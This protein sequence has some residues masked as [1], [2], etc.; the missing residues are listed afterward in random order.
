LDGFN[1]YH[2]ADARIQ[3]TTANILNRFVNTTAN[4]MI[5]A[6]PSGQTVAQGG[7][8]G[9][10][11]TINP[12]GGFTGQVTLSVTGLPNGASGGFTANPAT[13]S[14][15]LSVTTSPSTP[16]GTYALIITGVSGALIHSTTVSL[17]VAPPGVAFDNKVSSDF[18]FGVATVTTPSFIIGNG[19]HRAAM[20][21]VT[22]S[23][24]GATG[25]TASLGGVAGTI[26]AGTDSGTTATIRTMIF[27]VINPPSGPQT[28]TVSWAGSLVDADVGVIT[29]MGADQITPCTN[30]TFGA[31]DSTPTP[32]TSV[33][34][35]SAPGDLTAS[36]GYTADAWVAPGTNETPGWGIDQG[37]AGGDIGP[38]TGT[39]TH[40]WTDQYFY[41][42]QAVSGANFMA[43]ATP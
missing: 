24:N 20:I 40:T 4:F 32:A 14:T 21:M 9:Y 8:A 33:T 1:G 5:A 13:A 7:A 42:S 27:Q 16:T 19:S 25:I 36:V 10:A 43:S 11:V 17:T 35:T 22:M 23:A 18:Q 39:T 31:S 38:G 2:T 26:V 30:G 34:I 29:V 12:T 3:Q 41:Q 28:A 6:S 37:A 15:T